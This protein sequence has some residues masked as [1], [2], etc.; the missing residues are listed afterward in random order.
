M[1]IAADLT[2]A[3]AAELDPARVAAV[4]LAFGSP[5]AHSAILLRAKG[6]PVIVGAG[7]DGAV[8]FP[9]GHGRR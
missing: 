8:A 6:I 9:T 7:P 5:H 3:E 4:L 2:P 1:L